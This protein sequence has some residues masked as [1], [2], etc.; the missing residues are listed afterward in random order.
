MVSANEKGQILI[1]VSL[2][3]LLVVLIFFAALSHLSQSK[4][5]HQKYQFT[6]EKA[7]GKNPPT[8]TRY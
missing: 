5:R 4:A 1:E 6:Q 2:V 8:Q 3:L 7:H